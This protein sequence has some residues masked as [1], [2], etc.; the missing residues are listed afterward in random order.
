MAGIS[1]PGEV[2]HDILTGNFQD[3][4]EL[5]APAAIFILL[6]AATGDLL[7]TFFAAPSGAELSI[8]SIVALGREV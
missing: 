4:G 5:V 7:N 8:E 1:S 2:L 6:P 3:L